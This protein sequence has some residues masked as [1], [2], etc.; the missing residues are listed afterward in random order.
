MGF[1]SCYLHHQP[2]S[3]DLEELRG[4]VRQGT[5]RGLGAW[6]KR[7]YL[8]DGFFSQKVSRPFLRLVCAQDSRL[9][10]F[11]ELFLPSLAQGSGNRGNSGIRSGTHLRDLWLSLW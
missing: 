8:I 9:L 5:K 4:Q 7:Q 2:L 11:K 6:Q 1:G 3:S 10:Y